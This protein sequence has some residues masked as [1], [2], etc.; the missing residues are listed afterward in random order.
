MQ[1]KGRRRQGEIRFS[2]ELNKCADATPLYLQL[3]AKIRRLIADGSVSPGER[4]PSI[5]AAA[6]FFDIHPETVC[7]AYRALVE[8]GL[9]ESRKGAGFLTAAD[10]A[11]KVKTAE[12]KTSSQGS[13]LPHAPLAH[14]ASDA[15]YAMR[16]YQP[17]QNTIR[18]FAVYASPMGVFADQSFLQRASRIAR[19]PWRN[20][21]YGSPYGDIKLRKAIARRIRQFKGIVCEPEQIILTNGTNQ[22]LNLLADVLFEEHDKVFLEDPSYSAFRKTLAFKG[23]SI[24]P[25]PMDRDGFDIRKAQILAPEAKAAVVSASLQ[26]PTGC[27]M[28]SENRRLLL[29]WASLKKRW[30]IEDDTNNLPWLQDN[31]HQPLRAENGT[32]DFVIY[33]ESL[34]LQ[35]F[36]SI[37]TGFIIAPK[38]ITEALAGARFLTDRSQAGPIQ[39]LL[40]EFLES[41]AYESYVRRLTHQYALRNRFFIQLVQQKLSAYGHLVGSHN[42]AFLRFD[43]DQRL[44]DKI[45]HEELL[46]LGYQ[47]F[48]L[49]SYGT[50][51]SSLNGLILGVG[52]FNQED[53]E[54]GVSAIEGVCSK[55]L[56]R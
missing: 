26:L 31:E 29:E 54:A 22:S 52:A 53:I 11:I 23:A 8:E 38:A 13:D 6:E 17:S 30:I 45:V 44:A 43:L 55:L 33:I 32:E 34:S 4:L 41:D 46:K 25:V 15:Q 36:P 16:H 5:R 21:G 18:P 7:R 3:Q 20:T 19:T 27:V 50:K 2:G 39:R 28:S 14:R 1:I 51:N 9:I 48:C 49:S 40:A 56:A 47:S 37:R 12:T 24:V 35:I 42:A 10:I